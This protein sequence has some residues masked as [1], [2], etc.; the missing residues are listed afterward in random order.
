M[1]DSLTNTFGKEI[2]ANVSLS[3]SALD[4]IFGGSAY[5]KLPLD[6]KSIYRT[7][8]N[9]E[10]WYQDEILTASGAYISEDGVLSRADCSATDTQ[11]CNIT[12]LS[13]KNISNASTSYVRS[14][15]FFK[16]NIDFTDL[17][18]SEGSLYVTAN[19]ARAWRNNSAN[20]QDK[21]NRDRECQNDNQI[22][23]KNSAI[24]GTSTE[25][26]YSS[27][28]QGYERAD[29]DDVRHYYFP[30]LTTQTFIDNEATSVAISYYIP[31]INRS[32]I[33][34]NP[35][36]DFISNR[37]NIDPSV[38][39]KEIASLPRTFNEIDTIRRM[40]KGEDYVLYAYNAV[41]QIQ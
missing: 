13:L 6:F 14:S 5:D 30:I 17:G 2:R 37:V 32:G 24:A 28:S 39:V 21:N 8:V 35:P 3:E 15:S 4:I 41:G 34:A 1:S 18:I 12:E 25:F 29:C 36:Y 10:G 38:M 31:D 40:F 19:D 26:Q 33:T 7:D 27:Y 9:S 16:H 20:W 23:F 22:R 11:L